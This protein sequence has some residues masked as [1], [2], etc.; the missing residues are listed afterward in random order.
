MRRTLRNDGSDE[1]SAWVAFP[2]G[3]FCPCGGVAVNAPI[4]SCRRVLRRSRPVDRVAP[5]G[6]VVDGGRAGPIPDRAVGGASL[7]VAGRGASGRWENVADVDRRP[8]E[9]DQVEAIA[10]TRDPHLGPATLAGN[11]MAV[12]LDAMIEEVH[13]PVLGDVG[14]GIERRLGTVPA[15]ST[16]EN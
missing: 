15:A 6:T 13:E 3:G 11:R 1:G 14:G 12:H 7:R 5:K 8:R 16:A 4:A 10:R 2:G 9:R